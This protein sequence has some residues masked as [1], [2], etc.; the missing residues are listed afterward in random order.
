[1]IIKIQFCLE[2]VK[3]FSY[4]LNLPITLYNVSQNINTLSASVWYFCNFN[5][6]QFNPKTMCYDIK[7]LCFVNN[8]LLSVEIASTS[9]VPS[10]MLDDMFIKHFIQI[11]KLI[12]KLII[13]KNAKI[14]VNPWQGH[15]AIDKKDTSLNLCIIIKVGKYFQVQQFRFT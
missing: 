15:R 7:T 9:N 14:I 6:N 2:N 13:P 10:Y 12:Q 3:N 5:Y 1:M 8:L 4:N 11:L